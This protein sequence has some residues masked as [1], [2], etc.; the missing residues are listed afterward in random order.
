MEHK[1]SARPHKFA[2]IRAQMFYSPGLYLL[3]ETHQ[4]N[5][6]QRKA[7]ELATSFYLLNNG[8]STRN[9]VLTHLL[10]RNV[11]QIVRPILL[12]IAVNFSIACL[13]FYEILQS[14]SSWEAMI[15]IAFSTEL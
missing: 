8:T 2:N 13:S 14:Q 5:D 10:Q 12:G 4:V 15:L 1:R 3:Q 7:M 9:G 11:Q 6:R